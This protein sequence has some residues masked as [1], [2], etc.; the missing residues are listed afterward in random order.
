MPRGPTSR[1]PPRRPLSRDR[2][3][4]TA[5]ALAD[6]E[7]LAALSMRRVAR[8]LG[9]QAMSLYNH[10]ASKDDLIGAMVEGVVAEM[11]APRADLPWKEAMRRRALSAHAVLLRHPWAIMP[12]LSRI[13]AGPV[14]L[15]YADATIGCLRAAGF[16]YA[17]A[18]YAWHAIDAHVYGFTLQALNFPFA[19]DE[20]ASAAEDHLHL[21]PAERFPHLRGMAEEVMSGRHDG[22]QD[23][24]FGLD[25][26]LDGLERRLGAK[27]R[28]KRGSPRRGRGTE[29]GGGSRS[30]RA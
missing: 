2:V 15:A 18:D 8:A 11:E 22:L 9:V 14:M 6:A 4:E 25:L 19:P 13:N 7:G 1:R 3:T 10:V 21:I 23:I 28:A 30:G 27:R 24:T 12:L 17:M 20:Y 29:S 26:I 16:S 5:I